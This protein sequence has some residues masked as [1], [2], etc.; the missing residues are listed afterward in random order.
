MK[1]WI[2]PFSPRRACYQVLCAPHRGWDPHGS[3]FLPNK[4]IPMHLVRRYCHKL[5]RR[6]STGRFGETKRLS[7]NG[8]ERTWR[9]RF[10]CFL[11]PFRFKTFWRDKTQRKTLGFAMI[12]PFELNLKI[13]RSSVQDLN[14]IPTLPLLAPP[15]GLIFAWICGAA[16]LR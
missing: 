10:V 15:A 11:E 2:T 14:I 8:V 7:G 9:S 1:L 12:P 3:T 16:S 5:G 13:A 6:C 4:G